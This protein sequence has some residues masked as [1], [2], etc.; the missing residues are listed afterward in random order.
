MTTDNGTPITVDPHVLLRYPQRI[1]GVVNRAQMLD[2]WHSGVPVDVSRV[3]P[4]YTEARF[5]AYENETGM[6]SVLF[7]RGNKIKTGYQVP[8]ERVSLALDDGEG[9]EK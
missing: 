3:E 6:A 2:L 8:I 1:G 7:S 5:V 4:G 9:S